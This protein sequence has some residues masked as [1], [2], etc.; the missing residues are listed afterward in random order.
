MKKK[1]EVKLGQFIKIENTLKGK[2]EKDFYIAIQ[3]EDLDG[4]YER[5]ILFTEKELN[6]AISIDSSNWFSTNLK[7]GRIYPMLIGKQ[8]FFLIKV[9]D[10]NNNEKI[11]KL[12]KSL[13]NKGDERATKNPEDLTKKSFLRDL[14]D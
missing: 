1:I 8:K 13:L 5:C 11:L 9:F 4:S 2:S 3:V 7:P 12:T 14:F 6:D 10:L